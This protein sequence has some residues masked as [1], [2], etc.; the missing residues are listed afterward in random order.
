MFENASKLE[1]KKDFVGA[2]AAYKQV[3][4]MNPKLA[5]AHNALG[6]DAWPLILLNRTA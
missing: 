3:I 4:K 5:A 2:A 6:C 1:Q